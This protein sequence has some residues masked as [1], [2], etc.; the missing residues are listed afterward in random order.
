MEV[1]DIVEVVRPNTHN[2]PGI[3]VGSRG[4]VMWGGP[5]YIAV[6]VDFGDGF[7]WP[8]WTSEIKKIKP[9]TSPAMITNIPGAH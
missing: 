1:G 7:H 9:C 2:P 8:I 6:G 4:V 3:K 5:L